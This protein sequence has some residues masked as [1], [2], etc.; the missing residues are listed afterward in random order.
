MSSV[1]K[2]SQKLHDGQ[3]IKQ[4]NLRSAHA[5]GHIAANVEHLTG[6]VQQI[7]DMAPYCL[8]FN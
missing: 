2:Y 6:Q 7:K 4:H 1:N 8:V 3:A 5:L